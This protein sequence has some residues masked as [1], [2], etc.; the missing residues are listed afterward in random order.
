MRATTV[1]FTEDLW[2]LL[3]QESGTAGVSA[4]QFVRDATVLRIAYLMGR[5]GEPA[6]E[7]TLARITDLP[8]RNG[9]PAQ[10]WAVAG[11]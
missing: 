11:G 2:S 7:E 3:E 1:R 10:R 4:A 9:G 5:R 6:I 8:E